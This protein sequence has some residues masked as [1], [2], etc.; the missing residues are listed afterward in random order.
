MLN[1]FSAVRYEASI[2]EERINA[3]GMVAKKVSI[4]T[5]SM[6]NMVISN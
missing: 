4:E 5:L 6:L 2:N 3:P 1:R